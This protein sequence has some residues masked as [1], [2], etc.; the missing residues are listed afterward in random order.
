MAEGADLSAVGDD[1]RMHLVVHHHRRDRHVAGRQRLGAAQDVRPHAEGG[2]A[3]HVAG[4]A[5]TA[6]DLVGD[7]QQVVFRQHRLH[8]LEIGGGRHHHAAGAHHRFGDEGGDGVRAF[9]NDELFQRFGQPCGEGFLAL[10]GFR[11]VVV[12]GCVG[13]QE[14]VERQVEVA[15]VGVEPAEAGGGHRHPVVGPLAGDDLFL[16]RLADGVV[17]VPDHLHRAV[18]GLGTRVGEEHPRHRHRCQGQQAFGQLH[19]GGVGPLVERVVV[20]QG[21]QR[22][23]GGVGQAFVAEAERCAPQARH[24]FEVAV[25]GVVHHVDAVALHDHHRR[26]AGQGGQVGVAVQV[27]G[28]VLLADGSVVL[29]LGLSGGVR[30]RAAQ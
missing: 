10:A 29:H 16:G 19:H 8:L 2:R 28:D 21:V 27:D 12:V 23:G 22:Q 24:A 3:E 4:A 15:V 30:G 1:G 7:Q 14:T 25:A 17:V 9:R 13:V 6:N 20:G 5:E 18:V 26:R 11:A